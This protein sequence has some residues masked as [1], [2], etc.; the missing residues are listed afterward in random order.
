MP[1]R[2]LPPHGELLRVQ[3]AAHGDRLFAV[4]DDETITYSDLYQR[5]ASI[6]RGLYARGMRRGDRIG[7]LM[8]NC[9]EFFVTHLAIQLLGAITVT[10]NARYK[11]FELAHAVKKSDIRLLFT[12]DR[13][14]EHVNFADLLCQALPDLT[15]PGVDGRRRPEGTLELEG[16]PRLGTVVLCGATR[17]TPFVTLESLGAEGAAVADRDWVPAPGSVTID[18]IAVVLFTSG[19]TAAPKACQLTHRGLYETWAHTYPDAVGIEPG[20]K[21]WVPMPCFHVGGVGLTISA[22]CRGATFLTSIHHE[23]A[24][25][26]RLIRE[27]GVEHLYPGFFTLML[28]VMRAPG[29]DRKAV[30]AAR[31]MV[32]VAPFETHLMMK[33]QL[34][35]NVMILQLF[36]MSEASGYVTFTR[37]E[38]DET[39]RLNTNGTPIEG[40]EVRVVDSDT[41]AV[42]P[43]DVQGELQFRGPNS[44]HSYYEDEAATRATIL[45]GGW[46]RTGDCG[47][48]DPEGCTYFLG[49]I[50]DMLKVG[51][52]NVAAA[53]IEA[54]LGRH[55]AVKLT[56]VVGRADE[57][58]GEVA[59]AFVELL[60]GKQ[61]TEA[62]LIA[63]CKGRLAS[64]KIPREVRFVT[65][66][67]MSSTKIQKFKLREQLKDR[68]A[69]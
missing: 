4:V 42:L 44:F 41:G 45:E 59:V 68:S 53:E 17:R 20:E 55:P 60:P 35:S 22:L 2:D 15:A 63:F 26:L 28:P 50:K 36:G 38:K 43:P 33:E 30:L 56:Q 34:P 14:D 10:I 64:F 19:T 7:I 32:C 51:G 16:A 66:W 39:H 11:S 40:V 9:I 37:P 1:R 52:E 25:A 65:E 47:R 29:Y 27:Y 24:A 54:F 69:S 13:I 48:I 5:A 62:E 31:S 67:P 18:D 12:T 58:Y 6:A 57:R 3:A 21:I 49:R 46:V 61:A 8:P 23:G